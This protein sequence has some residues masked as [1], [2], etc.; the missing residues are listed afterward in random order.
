MKE[1]LG[2]L[3]VK[4]AG[5]QAWTVSGVSRVGSLSA[6]H[7]LTFGLLVGLE[8]VMSRRSLYLKPAM[9]AQRSANRLNFSGA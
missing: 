7:G 1:M 6:P 5:S 4:I 2:P 9:I 3:M 8:L